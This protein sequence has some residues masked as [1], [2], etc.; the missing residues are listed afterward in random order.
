MELLKQIPDQAPT[1][2]PIDEKMLARLDLYLDF[3]KA[4]SAKTGRKLEDCLFDYTPIFRTLTHGQEPDKEN[5]IWKTYIAGLESNPLREWTIKYGLEQKNKPQPKPL[6]AQESKDISF[7]AGCVTADIEGNMVQLHFENKDP[8]ESGPLSKERI[9]FR[10][11]EMRQI[12][13]RIRKDY[14]GVQIVISGSWLL[15]IPACRRLLPAPFVDAAQ[16]VDTNKFRGL[17]IWGQFIDKNGKIKQDLKNELFRKLK[18]VD[19]SNLRE[20]FPVQMMETQG[21][22]SDFYKEYGI[23]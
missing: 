17:G 14:S 20:A 5:P 10:R 12:F 15:S 2:E 3:A 18:E 7:S 11:E 16:V 4:A 8:S 23:E 13:S 9:P 6:G 22:I 19:S 1:P 21:P